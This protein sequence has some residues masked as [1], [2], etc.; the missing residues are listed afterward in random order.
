[1]DKINLASAL[2]AKLSCS[3]NL[4]TDF[5]AAFFF[6][7]VAHNKDISSLS[8]LT[9]P[10]LYFLPFFFLDDKLDLCAEIAASYFD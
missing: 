5:C 4:Q 2:T 7:P 10:F 3:G 6:S 8:N 9:R 1:M